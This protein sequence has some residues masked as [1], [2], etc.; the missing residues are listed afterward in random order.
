[1]LLY[2]AP[3]ANPPLPA[4]LI[5]HNTPVTVTNPLAGPSSN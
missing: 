3:Y 2:M 1:M 4:H 5:Q